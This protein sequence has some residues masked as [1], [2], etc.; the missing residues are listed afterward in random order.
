[1][2]AND[3]RFIE[4][5]NDLQIVNRINSPTIFIEGLSQVQLGYPN[6]YLVLHSRAMPKT[7]TSKERREVGVTLVMPTGALIEMAQTLLGIVRENHTQLTTA[8]SV[9]KE[10]LENMIQ[11]IPDVMTSGAMKPDSK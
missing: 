3:N 11:K 1:M 10:A 5:A 4:D 8:N 7:A 6:S 9:I 2:T